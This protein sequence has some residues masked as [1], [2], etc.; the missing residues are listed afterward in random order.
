G[1]PGGGPGGG[2]GGRGALSGPPPASPGHAPRGY[3]PAAK[4]ATVIVHGVFLEPTGAAARRRCRA[5]ARKLR[6]PVPCPG[7]APASTSRAPSCS[8][9]GGATWSFPGYTT[10]FS[11]ES[12]STH[13]L[14]RISPC[15]CPCPTP[16][17]G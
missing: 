7:V 6:Y 2:G 10:V 15:T 12:P 1:R 13:S 9:A 14:P 17:S 5:A 3:P 11:W 16:S 4:R 8:D